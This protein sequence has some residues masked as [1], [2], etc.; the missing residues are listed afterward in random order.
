MKIEK[1]GVKIEKRGGH[2][3][4]KILKK[5]LGSMETKKGGGHD[6]ARGKTMQITVLLLSKVYSSPFPFLFPF[7][8][9]PLNFL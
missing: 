8:Y 4:A 7:T 9:F 1:G 6:Y 5:N 2:D 3:Y